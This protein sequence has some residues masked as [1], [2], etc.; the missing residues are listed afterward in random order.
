M[1]GHILG[2]P[3]SSNGDNAITPRSRNG[4]QKT[5][6][7]LMTDAG[8]DTLKEDSTPEQ[9]S[10]ATNRFSNLTVALDPVLRGVAQSD[11]IKKLK[12]I[13]I[14][15][16]GD[17]VR[18]TFR[19][20]TEKEEKADEAIAFEDPEPW[21]EEVSAAELLKEI[22][23]LLKL[24]TVLPV[25]ADTVIALWVLFAWCH[26]SFYVSPYLCFNSPTK[27]CGKSTTLR[28][29]SKLVPRPLTAS[30][31]T[32]SSFFRSIEHYQP[33][34]VLDE[35]DTFLNSNKE[36]NGIIN[37]G[38]DRDGA[39]VL[40]TE[41][42]DH[43]PKPFSVWGP[44]VF[45]GIGRRKDTLEDRSII[46]PMKRKSTSEK[47][48]KLR[49]DRTNN[50]KKFRQKAARWAKDYSEALKE[51]DPVVPE[52]LNDRAQDNWRTL[53]AI[54]EIA[55]GDWPNYA[56]EAAL[57]FSGDADQDDD[58]IPT[59]LI[60]DIKAVF[61]AQGVE[62]ISSEDLVRELVD[63]EDRPWPEYRDGRPIT[64]TGVA[65][66]LKPFGVRPKTIRLDTGKVL[67]GYQNDWFAEVFKIYL[68]TPP[69]PNVTPVTTFE[70]KKL[71]DYSTVTSKPSVTDEISENLF[72]NKAVTA[73]TDE[74]GVSEDKK[75]M[76][77]L[78]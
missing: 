39:Y 72:K 43:I 18:Q 25:G 16:A 29:I 4:H 46:I 5:V 49:I 38:H 68:A 20:G 66:I 77:T 62:R 51:I 57:I 24:Y 61:E 67:K 30:N 47:V 3:I 69:N 34:L 78:F 58:S 33:T 21:P 17:L 15:G 53:M 42:D 37:A 28:I 56:K 70:N 27:R 23:S 7:E 8:V 32:T 12:S 36:L 9:I 73:V 40:R 48:E 35:L 22:R 19:V 76:G 74:I 52:S 65:R 10:V 31:I 54:A 75:E 59:Q 26:D 60:A 50:F 13:N 41:G 1:S 11:L 14:L 55:G 44:R 63:M 71:T 45:A 6:A 64:K 2:P